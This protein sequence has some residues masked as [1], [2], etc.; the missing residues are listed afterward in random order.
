MTKF[1]YIPEG[2]YLTRWSN[3]LPL[4]FEIMS[5]NDNSPYKNNPE[6]YLEDVIKAVNVYN[7]AYIWGLP[8]NIEFIRSE[9]EIIY[10]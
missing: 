8:D 2:R 5:Y 7:T 4:I 9:F 10:D 3:N 6:K 1:L